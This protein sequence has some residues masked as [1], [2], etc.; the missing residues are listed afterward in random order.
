MVHKN[1]CYGH[2]AYKKIE[3]FFIN[4]GH[5][6]LSKVMT[7]EIICFRK[8]EVYDALYNCLLCIVI[9]QFFSKS[10]TYSKECFS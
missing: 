1:M 3:D 10:I 4:L 2:I 6:I 8:I 7:L 5:V 9:V